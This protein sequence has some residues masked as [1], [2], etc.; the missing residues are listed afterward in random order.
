MMQAITD[1]IMPVFGI[2]LAGYLCGRWRLLGVSGSEALNGFV[3]YA[4]L[5]ALFFGAIVQTRLDDIFNWPFIGAYAF[6]M[7]VV[8]MAALAIGHFAFGAR[9]ETLAVQNMAALFANTGYMGI[10][11]CITTFGPA[12]AL[13]AIVATIVNGAVIM[14][15]YILWIEVGRSGGRG[16]WWRAGRGLTGMM[17]S[18]LVLSA[19]AGLLANALELP[20]PTAVQAFCDILGQAAPPAALFAMGLF[21]VGKS[22][23]GD[24]HDVAAMSGLKLILHPLATLAALLLMPDLTPSW[25]DPLLVLSALPTGSLVF[26]LAAKY[27][28]YTR[29]ATGIILATTVASLATLSG[30]LVYLDVR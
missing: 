8:A 20:I 6:G 18:P 14:A 23:A 30:L 13:P 9:G 12:A 3:Y 19:A 27:E 7:G 10:P 29:R 28:V 21:M 5:P 2:I 11:L 16:R 4:A 1:I 22:F 25:R 17:K 15:L 26:V 24:W